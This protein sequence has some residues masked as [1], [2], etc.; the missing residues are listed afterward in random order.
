MNRIIFLS[1]LLASILCALSSCKKDKSV[2]ATCPPSQ[3]DTT[4]HAIKWQTPDT[5]GAMGVIRDVWV[6]DR[7]NSWAVGEIYL[8]DSTGKP[9][10]ANPYN[11]AYWNGSKWELK[12]ILFYT[13]CGQQS[14][15]AYP[16]SS[17]F[18]FSSTDIWIAVS[19]S[20]VAR[21]N[22]NTQTA[23]MCLPVSFSI[24]KLWGENP[25]S[26]Y[27]V[28]YDGTNGM[29]LHF[30]GSSWTKMTSNTTVDLQDIWGID[31]SHIWAT[32]FNNSDGHC[33]V[34]QF[35]GTDWSSIY[36]SANLPPNKKQYYNTVWT[37]N[38]NYL[39][40]D[41]GSFTQI[42]NLQDGMFKRTDSLSSNEVFKIRG[43][44]QNDIFR[45]GYGG[46]TVHYNGANWYLFPELKTLNGGTAWF[47][48]VFPASDMVIIGGLFPTALNGFP[49][50]VRGY[51]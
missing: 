12:R 49:V 30:N 13:I 44:K 15:T 23:T 2:C 40:L 25:N 19:G 28:G 38:V 36:D 33:V 22:G 17:I 1:I 45:V 18:A 50:V 10:M 8:N 26:V 41:G 5:L 51:R 34:L 48:S 27:A 37:N 21:W 11:A 6:F 29:I 43:T 7:N 14:R 42:L 9:N 4:S 24:N 3:E 35:N 47:Y 20:Q 31:G 32:G 16:T 39:Y 46:E